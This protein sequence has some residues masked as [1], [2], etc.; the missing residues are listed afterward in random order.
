MSAPLQ[1]DGDRLARTL[2]LFAAPEV[3]GTP[4]GGVSRPAGSDADGWAR[5][6][7]A[8]I[9]HELGL[10]VRVDDVGNMYAERAGTDPTALPVVVGSH[11]DTVVPGGRFDGILGVALAFEAVAV[12]NQEGLTTRRSVIVVNWTGEEGARFPPAMLGSGV[13]TGVW[14]GHFALSRTDADGIRL[15]DELRRIG[16]L[17][18]A[19][20]RLSEFHAALEAHIEQGTQLEDLDADVGIVN[21]ISSVRWVTVRVRGTGG[22]AGGPGPDGRQEA[23]VAASRM[24]VAARDGSLESDGEFKT[25]VGSIHAVPGSNNVIPHDVTFNLDIRSEDDERVDVHLARLTGRF[26]GIAEDEGVEVSVELHW[27]L[28]SAPFDSGVRE[29]LSKVA[30]DQGV[31]WAPLRGSIG[32][33]ALHLASAG[34]TAML[35]TRTTGGL[36]HC[37]EEHAPWEAVVATCRVL[38]AAVAVLAEPEPAGHQIP[39][40]TPA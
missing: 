21:G 31:R 11:L 14:D 23:L 34:P 20:N 9:A 30:S 7:F 16:F 6:R 35:F 15:D 22:H 32:H 2:D 33:D 13:V 29:L 26:E 8:G 24:V 27:S 36:S 18:S 28:T 17:G 40:E 38:V 25:T 1:P 5:T 10:E 3:G 4:G 12:L 39:K 19:E 37:E